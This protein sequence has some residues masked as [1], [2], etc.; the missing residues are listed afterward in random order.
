MKKQ[1]IKN[2][3]IAISVLAH[4]ALDVNRRPALGRKKE[5]EEKEKRYGEDQRASCRALPA[6]PNQGVGTGPN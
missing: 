4:R 1:N 5:K 2:L 6:N 3:T